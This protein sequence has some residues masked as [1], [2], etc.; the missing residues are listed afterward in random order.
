M[1]MALLTSRSSAQAEPANTYSGEARLGGT[2]VNAHR[3]SALAGGGAVNGTMSLTGLELFARTTAIGIYGRT[4]SGTSNVVGQGLGGHFQLKEVRVVIGGTSF[5]PEFGLLRRSTSTADSD[6]VRTFY[7]G[8]LRLQWEIGN[9]GLQ[10][11]LNGGAYFGL[12]RAPDGDKLKYVGPTFEGTLLYQAPRRLPFYALAG[13]RYERFDD[14]ALATQRSE[15]NSGPFFGLGIRLGGR[16]A[17][18]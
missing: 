16:S 9:S 3:Q 8:G 17:L 15:E 5:S 2:F 13:W 7:R 6:S 4:L 18:R 12:N 10:V 14:Y 1:A 11:T